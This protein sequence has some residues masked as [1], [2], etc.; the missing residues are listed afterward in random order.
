MAQRPAEHTPA[1]LVGAQ[2]EPQVPQFDV[3]VRSDDS[4]P[5]EGFESQL[6]KPVS[7]AKEQKP[8][9]HVTRAL[10]PVGH[11]PPQRPQLSGSAASEVSQPFEGSPSQSA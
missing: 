9:E 1:A 3:S 6:A 11:A 8:D 4:H 2:R 10:G 7:H 5:F